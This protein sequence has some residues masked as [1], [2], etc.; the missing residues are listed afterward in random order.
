MKEKRFEFGRN[1]RGFLDS[2]DEATITAAQE[3][4]KD[5][6]GAENLSGKSFLDAGSGSG[7]FSLSAMRLGASRVCSFDYDPDSV[8]CGLVLKGRYF[9][10]EDR[11]RI[12]RG[13]VL[14]EAY[15]SGLGTF[16][17]V[18]SWGVLHHTGN[19]AAA[20]NNVIPLVKSG[21]V[22][23][24]A[25]YNKQPLRTS[26]WTAIKKT[27]VAAPS[28][29]KVIILWTYLAYCAVKWFIGDALRMNNPFKR[30]AQNPDSR[31]GMKIYRDA[32]D[33]IGGY[34][35]QTASSDEVKAYYESRGFTLEN[36]ISI[37]SGSG[38]NEYVF[39]KK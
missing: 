8:E 7:L 17:V 4:L 27:Y 25:I 39:N 22:L 26:V 38:N 1:W 24:I 3:S 29:V 9:P 37:G 19:L 21:G 20:M 12:E 36:L 31:R 2:V 28:P 16:D 10:N 13:S 35:F 32:V 23:A 15:L 18:Y 34:P 11:W 6:L 5:L 14:D 30:Y 33:W